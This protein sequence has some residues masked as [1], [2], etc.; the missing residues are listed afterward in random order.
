MNCKTLSASK[1]GELANFVE[2]TRNPLGLY[3]F[4]PN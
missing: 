1:L 2:N 4:T 3:T